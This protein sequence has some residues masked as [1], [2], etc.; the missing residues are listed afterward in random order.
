MRDEADCVTASFVVGYRSDRLGAHDPP[1]RIAAFVNADPDRRLGVAGID[2]LASSA[3]DDLAGARELGLVGVALAPADQGCRP[4][5]E[6]FVRVL[7]WCAE[8]GTPVFVNNPGLTRRESVMEFARPSLLDDALRGVEGLTI[9]LGDLGRVFL[10]EALILC[11]KHERC[12]AEIST[13]IRRPGAL[14]G[15]LLAAHECQ[16]AH[17]LLFGSGFPGERPERAI[18]RLY[19]ANSV[20]GGPVGGGGGGWPMVPREALRGIVERD[21]LRALGVDAIVGGPAGP[22]APARRTGASLAPNGMA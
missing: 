18:E 3:F 17:K 15:G 5:H 6:R 12:F 1:E 10:D 16:V 14:Y 7:E 2:P 11:T 8:H 20:T 22:P 19:S 21:A 13:L 4:T 9:V